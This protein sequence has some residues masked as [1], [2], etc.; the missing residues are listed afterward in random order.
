[1]KEQ[2]RGSWL[3]DRLRS[4]IQDGTLRRGQPLPSTREL[5]K[6]LG[7]A[8][9]TVIS[10]LEYLKDE[11]YLKSVPGSRIFIADT[12]P[13]AFLSPRP[14]RRVRTAA[15]PPQSLFRDLQRD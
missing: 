7:L 11:G 14:F 8:R 13:E 4:A 12:L 10:A 6:T 2:R 5:A 15:I 3:R 1:M 9:G